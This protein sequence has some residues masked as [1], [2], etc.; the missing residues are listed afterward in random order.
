M[1]K[2]T[3]PPE[4]D[5]TVKVQLIS[6]YWPSAEELSL[7]P[8]HLVPDQTEDE[9]GIA[10]NTEARFKAG[11]SA[12]LPIKSAFRLVEQGKAKRLDWDL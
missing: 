1:N 8:G 10:I 4:T 12:V 2:A 6:D 5:N 9:H 3:Q 7:N 11:S